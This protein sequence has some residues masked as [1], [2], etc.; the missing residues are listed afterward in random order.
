MARRLLI[1][2][3]YTLAFLVLFAFFVR[4]LFPT[5][6]IRQVAEVRLADA[7]GADNVKIGS[8]S[9]IGIIPSG[10]SL[11]AVDIDLGEV[12]LPAAPAGERKLGRGLLIDELNVR[13]SLGARGAL[14]KGP[15][16]GR[17]RAQGR[18]VGLARQV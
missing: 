8:A 15:V 13:T 9:L 16:V 10:L 18:V 6:A 12:V 17:V 14:G 5:D 2:G 4:V 1:G 7:L 3:G 11:S